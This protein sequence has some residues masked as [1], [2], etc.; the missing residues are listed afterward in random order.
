[1]NNLILIDDRQDFID[2]FKADCA[3]RQYALYP[4]RSLAG[5]KKLMPAMHHKTACVILDIKCLHEDDQE[6][7]DSAFI[8]SALT[9]MDQNFPKF[10]RLILTGDDK[11]YDQIKKYY[12]N[13]DIFLK[14]TDD[15]D[16]LF[17][18]IKYYLG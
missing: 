1:M 10:P 15:K 14:T 5:L 9:Y 8:G 11:E 6:I 2:A 12:K 13:E 3:A 17:V 16:R 18:K 7:E 4:E